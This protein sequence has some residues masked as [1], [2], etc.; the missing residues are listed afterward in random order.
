MATTATAPSVAAIPTA[1]SAP[2]QLPAPNSDFY[3][4]VDVL[5]A[6][7]LATVKKV[8]AYMETKVQPIINKYWSDDA[9]PFELLPSFKELKLGGLGFEGYGCAG[10]SHFCFCSSDPSR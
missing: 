6:E 9:F 5:N 7:E 4:L 3:Q 1:K 2:K 8:R 10:G